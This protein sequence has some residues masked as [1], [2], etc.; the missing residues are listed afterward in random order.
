MARKISVD[1]AAKIITDS[2]GKFITVT[3]VKR[4]NNKLRTMNCRVGVMKD[5]KGKRIRKIKPGL[6]RVWD[7][8]KKQYRNINISGLRSVKANGAEYIV[9]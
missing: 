1:K 2:K 6:V 9:K 4:T 7:T 8:T 5:L 3:F